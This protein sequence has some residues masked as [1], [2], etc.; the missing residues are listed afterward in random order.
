MILAKLDLRALLD[1]QVQLVFLDSQQILEQQVQQV[2][3]ELRE[4]QVQ[5]GHLVQ[6]VYKV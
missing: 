4:Q 2:L 1:K 6:Q 3:Q 5:R